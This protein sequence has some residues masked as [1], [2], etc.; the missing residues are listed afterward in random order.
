[1]E[2]SEFSFVLKPSPVGGVGVFAAHDISTGTQLF[3]RFTAT[4]TV[5]VKDVPAEFLKYCIYI[6]DDECICPEQFDRM[7]IGWYLNHSEEPNLLKLAEDVV[8]AKRDIKAGEELFIDY[9]QLNEPEHLKEPY[10][11]KSKELASI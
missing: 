5:N 2:W 8:I 1:M 4:R 6:S 11:A 7:E 9:N 10:Y 3:K